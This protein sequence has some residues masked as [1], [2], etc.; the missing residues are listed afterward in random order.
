M[1][2]ILIVIG[3]SLYVMAFIFVVIRQSITSE[4]IK[5][6]KWDEAKPWIWLFIEIV[7]VVA[8]IVH[9]WGVIS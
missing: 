8:P 2:T 9:F 5:W 6:T 1:T 3:I 7:M 4:A